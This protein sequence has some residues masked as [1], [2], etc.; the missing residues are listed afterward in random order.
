MHIVLAA[1]P[2]GVAT[3]STGEVARQMCKI[4]VSEV[5]ESASEAVELK[6]TAD[7]RFMGEA[8]EV[9]MA[10]NGFHGQG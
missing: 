8:G 9:E 5:K 10:V 6:V 3:L 2:Q 4:T 7:P 1:P